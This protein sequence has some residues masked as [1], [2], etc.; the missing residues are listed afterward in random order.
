[1]VGSEPVGVGLQRCSRAGSECAGRASQRVQWT[2]RDLAVAGGGVDGVR[3]TAVAPGTAVRGGRSLV[4]APTPSSCRSPRS[5][6]EG[7]RRS[8]AASTTGAPRHARSAAVT[9][10]LL[11]PG[12]HVNWVF[13]GCYVRDMSGI[14][15]GRGLR[16]CASGRR[17]CCTAGGTRARREAVGGACRPGRRSRGGLATGRGLARRVSLGVRDLGVLEAVEAVAAVVAGWPCSKRSG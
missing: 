4:K 10:S 12:D 6:R 3:A 14:K 8:R 16:P 11:A 9:R 17:G 2:T 15:H 1:M 7:Q 13:A 5:E